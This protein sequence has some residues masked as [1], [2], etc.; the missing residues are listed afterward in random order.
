MN[1]D[2]A[3]LKFFLSNISCLDELEGLLGKPNIFDILGTARTEIRHSNVLKWLL[4]P[5]G[6]HGLG[7]L[8]LRLFLQTLGKCGADAIRLLAVDLDSFLVLR[9]HRHIDLLVVSKAEKVVIAI[10]NKIDSG[11]HGNQLERYEKAVADEYPGF[12]QV[13]VFLSPEGR[14][15]SDGKWLSVGY[16][17]VLGAVRYCLRCASLAPEAELLVNQ[18]ASLLEREFM[19]RCKLMEICNR[20]YRDHKQA[21]DLI[22]EMRED[23]CQG[24]HDMIVSWFAGHPKSPLEWDSDH[25]SKTY[26]RFSTRRLRETVPPLSNGKR[27]GWSSS[28]SAYYE[29]INRPSGVMV[30][31]AASSVNMPKAVEANLVKAFGLAPSA[32]PKG[33]I[34]KTVK[35]L[36]AKLKAPDDEESSI[37][38]AEVDSFMEKL[39]REVVAFEATLPGGGKL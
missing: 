17:A 39:E 25:S 15:A 34:W 6:T 3:S 10:E 27:S 13:F 20:I 33:W 14:T 37:G 1:S 26:I 12:Y 29:I 18:Y 9:E 22:Y 2:E 32:L 5:A 35:R 7:G 16:D 11:E 23:E 36:S 38:Q 4:D 31:I 21:L 8:F 19:D 24:V 28:A 30:K